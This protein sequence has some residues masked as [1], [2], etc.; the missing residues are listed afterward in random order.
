L[1]GLDRGHVV[2]YRRLALVN[3]QTMER[4]EFNL[5]D[6]SRTRGPFSRLEL[7]Y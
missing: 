3:T 2:F 7:A 1:F 4:I 5:P 6:S